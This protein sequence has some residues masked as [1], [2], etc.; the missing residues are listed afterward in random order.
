MHCSLSLSA[1]LVTPQKV[2]TVVMLYYEH[3]PNQPKT[4]PPHGNTTN[5][6]RYRQ[7]SIALQAI[8][9]RLR[10]LP[11]ESRER[12]LQAAGGIEPSGKMRAGGVAG[13]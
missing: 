6:V 7:E 5:E 2:Q 10:T 13:H 8:L 12:I 11:L 9:Q 1:L 4:S 3:M